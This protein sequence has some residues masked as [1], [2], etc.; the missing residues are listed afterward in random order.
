[1][2]VFWYYKNIAIISKIV[3]M[4]YFSRQHLNYA[5]QLFDRGGKLKTELQ[6]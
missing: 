5:S 2:T 3:S 1:M 4:S 6:L